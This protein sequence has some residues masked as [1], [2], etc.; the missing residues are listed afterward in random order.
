MGGKKQIGKNEYIAAENRW[1]NI[2]RPTQG[3]QNKNFNVAKLA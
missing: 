1:R 3:S 2:L